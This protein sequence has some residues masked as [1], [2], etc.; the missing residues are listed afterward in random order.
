[1]RKSVIA[2]TAGAV[3]CAAVA[4]VIRFKMVP[5]AERVQNDQLS[6]IHYTG[7]AA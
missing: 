2:L 7:T 5:D 4:G 1:M 6:V 3:V